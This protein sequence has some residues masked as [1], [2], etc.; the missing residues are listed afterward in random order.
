[1]KK[2]LASGLLVCVAACKSPATAEAPGPRIELATSQHDFGTIALGDA[3]HAKFALRNAGRAPLLIHGAGPVLGCAA[4]AEP[5]TIAPSQRGALRVECSPRAT[6]PL[7][8]S[9]RIQSNDPEAHDVKLSGNVVPH[10]GFERPFVSLRIPF[11]AEQSEEIALIGDRVRDAEPVL[12]PS[13]LP[14]CKAELVGD[15][16]GPRVRLSCRGTQ[17]GLVSDVLKLSTGLDEPAELSL[18]YS[19]DVIGTLRISPTTPYFNMRLEGPKT[20][21]VEIQSPRP[22]FRVSRVEVPKGPF[23]ASLR[24]ERGRFEAVVS[25][26]EARWSGDERGAIGVLRIYSNDPSE[27]EKDVSLS[28]F[29]KQRRVSE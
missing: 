23:Q 24:E 15:E 12:T 26:D 1:V 14:G 20:V 22:D 29:G 21:V 18:P 9:L 10:F 5:S 2:R 25:V 19:V 17:V 8:V 11:G 6:G 4:S 3:V 13:V 27:P 16:R 7:S 28:A